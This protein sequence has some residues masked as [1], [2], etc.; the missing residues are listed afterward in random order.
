[1]PYKDPAKKRDKSIEYHNKNKNNEA[2]KEKKRKY[3][4]Q[5]REELKQHAYESII[6]GIINEQHKWDVWCNEIKR[7]NINHPYTDDFTNDIMFEMM[8]QG[9]F[10][11]G[12]IATTIDRIDSKLDHTLDN[13]VGCCLGC[14]NSKGVAD[15]ATFI[16][17]AYYRYRGEYYDDDTNIWFVHKKKP[18][19]YAYKGR[20]ENKGVSFELTKG[21]FEELISGDCEYCKR[22]PTTW[23][24]IDRIVPSLGY[25]FGNVVP[26]CCDC[27]TDKLE[28]DVESTISRN[29]RIANRVDVGELV[30]DECEKVILH[31]RH[32]HDKYII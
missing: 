7:G 23:F 19:I 30:I 15:T 29:K 18:S 20:A 10:Y 5:R 1:M 16:R 13:C 25:V 21:Y 3:V 14:N 31:K 26:C 11:C 28:D 24:G 8:T 17:K 4:A 2:Y 27:N 6:S 12:D 32:S 9:C 22:S